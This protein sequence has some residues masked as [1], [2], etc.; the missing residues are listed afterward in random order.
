MWVGE[1]GGF[2]RNYPFS[3]RTVKKEE[4]QYVAEQEKVDGRPNLKC[5]HPVGSHFW[6]L[7]T[8]QI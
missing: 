4:L 3:G 5:P 6:I 2:A 8:M 7:I 1:E